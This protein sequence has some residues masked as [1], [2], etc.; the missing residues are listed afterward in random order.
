MKFETPIIQYKLKL[1][2]FETS[3][4]GPDLNELR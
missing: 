3:E 2:V 4:T 1:Y